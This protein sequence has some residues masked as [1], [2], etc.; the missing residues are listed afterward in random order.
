MSRPARRAPAFPRFAQLLC[1]LAALAT[2]SACQWGSAGFAGAIGDR[3]FDPNGTVFTYL[4]SYDDSLNEDERPRVVVFMT[5]LIFDPSSDLRDVDGATLEGLKHE[6]ALRDAMAIV[7]DDQTE[8]TAGAAFESRTTS[9]IEESN[10]GLSARIHFAAERLTGAS[11]YADFR[12]FGSERVVTVTIDSAGFV[13]G[14]VRG[15]NGSVVVDVSAADSDPADALTG[16]LEGRFSAPLVEERVAESNLSLLAA[17][18][19]LGVP[20]APRP[21]EEE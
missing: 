3:T 19:V 6:L 18:G 4:D 17:D 2:S 11:T 10:D 9:G 1:A 7:F 16:R 15:V 20:L 21:V 8:V 13:D 12:P 5:W 14:G